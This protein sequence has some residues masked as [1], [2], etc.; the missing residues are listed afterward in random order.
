MILWIAERIASA[1]G[2][3]SQFPSMPGEIQIY[4]ENCLEGIQSPPGP[5]GRY[6]VQMLKNLRDLVNKPQAKL[7]LATVLEEVLKL[8]AEVESQNPFI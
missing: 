8:Q 3:L 5:L 4:K 7:T 6:V 2:I 1:E